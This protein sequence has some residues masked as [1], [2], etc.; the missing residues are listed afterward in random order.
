MNRIGT[1]VVIAL[2]A[3]ALGAFA[4]SKFWP[5]SEPGVT[6][7]YDTIVRTRVDSV[8]FNLLDSAKVKIQPVTIVVPNNV[9]STTV[10]VDSVEVRTNKYEGTE[11]LSNGTIDWT[12]Y[13]DK[14]YATEFKLTTKDTT[15]IKHVTETLPA[16]SRLYFMG[17]LDMDWVTK[18]PAGA[19]LGLMYNRRQKWGV[20]V[21]IRQDLSG[22]LPSNLATTAG[23][24][25]YVGL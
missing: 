12:V 9:I 5:G 1:Y 15:I 6:V 25:I 8:P 4:S 21:S 24:K 7:K 17:G 20:G 11:E 18:A 2:I 14:L 22:L 19:E 23:F 3:F 10:L 16:R 13:A